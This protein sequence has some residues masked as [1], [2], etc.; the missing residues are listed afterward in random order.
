MRLKIKN[1][2]FWLFIIVLW[3]AGMVYAW[4]SPT[5]NWKWYWVYPGTSNEQYHTD[6]SYCYFSSNSSMDKTLF[7]PVNSNEELDA[8]HNNHPNYVSSTRYLEAQC[9]IEDA[10][11]CDQ[12]NFVYGSNT[13]YSWSWYGTC[14]LEK[15]WKCNSTCGQ[16]TCSM[17]FTWMGNEVQCDEWCFVAGTMITMADW[18]KK[19]VESV[20][21]WDI[22]LGAWGIHNIVERLFKIDYRRKLY[23]LNGGKYFVS[24]THPFMTTEWWKS[25]DPAG[26]LLE[27]PD[28]MITKLE[29]GDVLVTESWLTTLVSVDFHYDRQYVYNFKTDGNHTYYADWFLVH[30][31]VDKGAL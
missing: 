31:P 28:L 5:S 21:T 1:N 27:N 8:F 6:W 15:T 17:T 12:G 13:G 16:E 29:A 9:S 20:I 25:F 2:M 19:H 24:D 4:F 30:N 11:V 14:N 10:D 3:I 22:L 18:T 23:S 26:S 7:I